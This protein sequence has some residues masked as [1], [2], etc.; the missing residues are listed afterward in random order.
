[1]SRKKRNPERY[2]KRELTLRLG[3]GELAKAVIEQWHNDGEPPCD[4]IA[5]D[6]W[7]DIKKACDPEA[8]K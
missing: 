3:Y 1:M 4:R 5:I 2:T 6:I 8:R 7:L